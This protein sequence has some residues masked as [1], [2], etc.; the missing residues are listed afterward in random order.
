MKMREGFHTVTPY[1]TTRDVEGLLL[2]IKRGL[3]GVETYRAKAGAGGL[4]VEVR[5]GDSMMMVG[6]GDNLQ[7][8]GATA[9]LLLYVEDVDDYYHRAVAA[10]ATSIAE[11]SDS[12]DGERRGGVS[13][14]F[15]NQWFF[16]GPRQ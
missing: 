14:P 11:P 13:D 15:G 8:T 2:F 1:L 4:H 12:N 10:G 5:I 7:G 6:G 3:G 9:M 16:G